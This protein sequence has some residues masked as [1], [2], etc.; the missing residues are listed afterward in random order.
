MAQIDT[1]FAQTASQRLAK[2]KE[3]QRLRDEANARA[4][5]AREAARLRATSPTSA[6]TP[7]TAPATGAA[8]QPAAS[9]P[10]AAP[11]QAQPT[12]TKKKRPRSQAK[13]LRQRF[14]EFIGGVQSAR[15]QTLDN[16]ISDS[17]NATEKGRQRS[18]VK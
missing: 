10:V 17:V 5:A 6:V 12:T 4:N 18:K 7:A 3:K 15:N 2:A 11:T 14:N 13:G 16:A 1:S 8:V 9:T